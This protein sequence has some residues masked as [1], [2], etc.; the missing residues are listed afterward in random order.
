M[1]RKR[2][3]PFLLYESTRPPVPHSPDPGRHFEGLALESDLYPIEPQDAQSIHD[4]TAINSKTA[5][6]KVVAIL[7]NV[8]L[9]L[10]RLAQ[11]PT[12]GL[13]AVHRPH[14][15]SSVP[16]F[17]LGRVSLPNWWPNNI[18]F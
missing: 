18:D 7:G 8:G 5:F 17:A 12:A 15:N 4:V 11:R 9:A 1:V 13:F 2:L 3:L 16:S 14:L 6:G 10:V